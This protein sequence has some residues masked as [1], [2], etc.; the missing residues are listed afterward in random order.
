MLLGH[1]RQIANKHD[2]VVGP[3]SF[4]EFSVQLPCIGFSMLDDKFAMKCDDDA[5][6][7]AQDDAGIRKHRVGEDEVPESNYKNRTNRTEDRAAYK[8]SDEAIPLIMLSHEF[9]IADP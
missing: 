6:A 3:I 5:V 8:I 2:L 1:P 7:D 4:H 9:A